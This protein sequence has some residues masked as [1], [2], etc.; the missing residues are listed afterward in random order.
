VA[1]ILGQQVGIVG[2]DMT[3]VV[4]MLLALTKVLCEG[5]PIVG[6]GID[7]VAILSIAGLLTELLGV[8]LGAVVLVVSILCHARGIYM[9]WSTTGSMKHVLGDS[10]KEVGLE[11]RVWQAG[12]DNAVHMGGIMDLVRGLQED[13]KVHMR[14][15][16]LLELHSVDI[17][18]KFSKQPSLDVFQQCLH[19]LVEYTCNNVRA[20]SSRL[21]R[22]ILI[23]QQGLL[24]LRPVG[25]GCHGEEDVRPVP[26]VTDGHR[27]LEELIHVACTALV[28]RGKDNELT[29]LPKVDWRSIILVA[30]EGIMKASIH[31]SMELLLMSP[32]PIQPALL[33]RCPCIHQILLQELASVEDGVRLS[34]A[35]EYMVGIVALLGDIFGA[36]LTL[37]TCLCWDVEVEARVTLGK[38]Q[39]IVQGRVAVMQMAD[40]PESSSLQVH[41]NVPV[42]IS[43][44]SIM[45]RNHGSNLLDSGG[46]VPAQI[47]TMIHSDVHCHIDLF[48]SWLLPQDLMCL[49]VEID[50]GIVGKEHVIEICHGGGVQVGVVGQACI[51]CMIWIQDVE[52]GIARLI[53]TIWKESTHL[54]VKRA[55]EPESIRPRAS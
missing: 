17:P 30:M 51:D 39:D 44:D 2:D 7:R 38:E 31:L 33:H 3:V 14:Q 36:P 25:V 20:I 34:E 15:A 8:V 10:L 48:L 13:E 27:V 49:P 23:L 16:T 28:G 6:P 5:T 4:D 42:Q 1:I 37:W 12:R 55:M 18:S 21:G 35:R 52:L 53:C 32:D 11:I 29:L 45:P 46:I 22:A 54:V 47:C 9:V 26:T 19:L 40:P 41:N 43:L 24:D 50:I